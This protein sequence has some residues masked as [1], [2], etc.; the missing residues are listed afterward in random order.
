LYITSNQEK[1]NKYEYEQVAFQTQYL[2][3]TVYRNAYKDQKSVEFMGVEISKYGVLA[4]RL[5]QFDINVHFYQDRQI[6]SLWEVESIADAA[7]GS[8]GSYLTLYLDLLGELDAAPVFATTT[9]V[10]FITN[11]EDLVRTQEDAQEQ[12]GNMYGGANVVAIVTS[13]VV[14]CV[15]IAG[16]VF[17]YYNYHR[18]NRRTRIFEEENAIEVKRESVNG[19]QTSRESQDDDHDDGDSSYA[20]SSSY[21]EVE[22][23][24]ES[25]YDEITLEDEEAVD[26]KKHVGEIKKS[27]VGTNIA[28]I[29]VRKQSSVKEGSGGSNSSGV[30]PRDSTPIR[31][32][33][34]ESHSLLNP[35]GHPY[36]VKST[37]S[38][39][40]P[41]P[42]L[43]ATAVQVV[44][45]PRPG[46]PPP[47]W[48][49][50]NLRPVQPKEEQR[51]DI[52]AMAKR[53]DDGDNQSLLSIDSQSSATPEFLK[54]FKQMGLAA[55]PRPPIQ[56]PLNPPPPIVRKSQ[57]DGDERSIVTIDSQSSTTPEF[58]K[59][60]KQMGL[61]RYKA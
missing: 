42:I 44:P 49:N 31:A 54:K 7:L 40:S 38:T 27:Y 50:P 47:V 14:S 29:K 58:L 23:V 15:L 55:N 32:Y 45:S 20:D 24:E 12:D 13:L 41:V 19:D 46:S 48:T 36:S 57:V 51:K 25:D 60:F 9:D 3:D 61:Q 35:L 39:G 33:P 59:K 26:Y 11:A 1:P 22:V 5:I 53:A 43:S 56:V 21:E 4:S 18:V 2:L 10:L 52:R 30:S 28:E 16:A 37:G 34:V 8:S 17:Y 6:P